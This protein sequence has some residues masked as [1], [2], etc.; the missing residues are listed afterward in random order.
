MLS[1]DGKIS[2]YLERRSD[3]A[4]LAIYLAL[5]RSERISIIWENC[6]ESDAIEALYQLS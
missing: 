3:R 2:A 1:T 4:D 5:S 6:P